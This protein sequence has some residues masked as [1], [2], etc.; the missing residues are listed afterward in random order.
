MT[1]TTAKKVEGKIEEINPTTIVVAKKTIYLPPEK[2]EWF[3]ATGQKEGDEVRVIY[4]MKGN[5]INSELLKAGE[6][7]EIQK[8]KY[9][10]QK[11]VETESEKAKKLHIEQPKK[12]EG[13]P[14]AGIAAKPEVHINT[15]KPSGGGALSDGGSKPDVHIQQTTAAP[16]SEP[17]GGGEKKEVHIQKETVAPAPPVVPER[18]WV[19]GKEKND[20]IMLQ[21]VLARSVEIVNNH[22]MYFPPILN[23]SDFT[24][25]LSSRCDFI[26]SVSD[27]LF[28]YVKKKLK[29]EKP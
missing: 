19:T 11:V 12:A 13:A 16:T 22:Y 27:R 26:E 18:D 17:Q 3:T 4:D 24:E 10:P 20:T 1:A 5:I 29:D 28:E 6:L 25:S 2:R 15:E 7:K 8:N 21:S 23:K 14:P 9:V